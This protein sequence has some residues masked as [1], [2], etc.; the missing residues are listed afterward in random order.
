MPANTV[1][2]PELQDNVVKF[3]MAGA[4]I[5]AACE[6]SGLSWDTAKK[7]LKP[8]MATKEPY[9]GFVAAMN[10]AKRTWEA[11]AAVQMTKH[12]Q[13]NHNALAWML[14]RRC[15]EDWGPPAQRIEI[16]LKQASAELDELEATL[17]REE[18]LK[19]LTERAGSDGD[20]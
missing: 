8:P 13:T 1:L 9:A 16:A 2:T 17:P 5:P 7:W 14:E 11:R 10:R 15:P 20:G 4:T 12:G 19:V 3:V 18:Y 6:A